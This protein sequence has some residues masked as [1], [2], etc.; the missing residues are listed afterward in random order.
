MS[1]VVTTLVIILISLVAIGIIWVVVSSII[2]SNTRDI[3]T[4]VGGLTTALEITN[5]YEQGVNIFVSIMKKSGDQEIGKVMF[6]LSNS[7]NDEQITLNVNGKWNKL[8][9]QS[10]TIIPVKF[11]PSQVE[12]VSI[13]PVYV[14]GG[15]ETIGEIADIFTLS[16]GSEGGS[17]GGLPGCTPDCAGRVCGADDGCGGLCDQET[18]ETGKTCERGVCVVGEACVPEDP[19]ITCGTRVCGS[20]ENNC[21]NLVLCPAGG[22]GSCPKGEICDTSTGVCNTITALNTGI[23]SEVWPGTSGLYFGSSDLPLDEESPTTFINKYIKFP[24]SS[25]PRCLQIVIYRL[26]VTGYNKAHIGFNFETS[27]ASGDQYA[28][29]PS[30]TECNLV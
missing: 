17:G 18:C 24:G 6:I 16:H 20:R 28:I 21:N 7:T 27:V 13:V 3:S 8:S 30:S 9:T 26:N 14:Y 23:V 15:D 5:A 11:T 12:T 1:G 29:Y 19:S 10:F 22:N 2:K 25:E 4:S